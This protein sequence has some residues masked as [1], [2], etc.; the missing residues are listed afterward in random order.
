MADSKRLSDG[1]R[2]RAEIIAAQAL[3]EAAAAPS[4]WRAKR[5]KRSFTTWNT[6]APTTDRSQAQPAES[7]ADPGDGLA[8]KE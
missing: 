1:A 6:P 2:R 3:R 7:A 4:N 5:K 8:A